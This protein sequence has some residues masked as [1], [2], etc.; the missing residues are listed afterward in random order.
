MTTSPNNVL[1]SFLNYLR[2]DNSH[3]ILPGLGAQI[4]TLTQDIILFFEKTRLPMQATKNITMIIL[5]IADE[6]LSSPHSLI[7][8]TVSISQC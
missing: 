7:K 3:K 4:L 6:I 1:Q 2:Q 5:S 8:T